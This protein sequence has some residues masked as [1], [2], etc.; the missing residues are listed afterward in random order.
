MGVDVFFEEAIAQARKSL[1]EGGIPIGAVLVCDGK[2]IGRGH[3]RRVQTGSPI[4]HAEMD[5]VQ[6]AGRQ[7]ASVYRRSVLY[8]TLSPCVMCSGM[9]R[10]YRIAEVVVGED[11]NF[12]GPA[13]E[14]R[15][16]GVRVRVLN[17]ERCIG[18]MR[19]FIREHPE[20][21]YEDIGEEKKG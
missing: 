19:D 8:S 5:A 18:M 10:L 11:V 7:P 16:A 1:A 17:D 9:V 21:W 15:A 3:N 13:D 4:L 14:L 12:Q 6:N 2:I 20:L